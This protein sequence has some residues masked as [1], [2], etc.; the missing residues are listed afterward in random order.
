MLSKHCK[1]PYIIIELL[2]QILYHS[3]DWCRRTQKEN[4]NSI[5]NCFFFFLYF[6]DLQ[7]IDMSIPSLFY[8]RFRSTIL[9]PCEWKNQIDQFIIQACIIHTVLHIALYYL[10]WIMLITLMTNVL[11]NDK[12]KCCVLYVCG[13][14]DNSRSCLHNMLLF[15]SMYN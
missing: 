4:Q 15:L 2:W 3:N 8:V 9:F 6:S 5:D 13:H 7:C 11:L 1:V 10:G 14:T 12:I